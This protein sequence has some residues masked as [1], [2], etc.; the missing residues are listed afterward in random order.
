MGLLLFYLG[1]SPLTGSGGSI[2]NTVGGEGGEEE[3]DIAN[4][5]G[6]INTNTNSSSSSSSRSMNTTALTNSEASA[7]T[8]RVAVA[9]EAN[10][11]GTGDLVKPSL[12]NSNSVGTGGSGGG[13]CIESMSTRERESIDLGVDIDVDKPHMLPSLRML[14]G[15]N[16]EFKQLLYNSIILSVGEGLGTEF[17]SFVFIIFPSVKHYKR[18]VQLATFFFFAQFVLGAAC[19]AIT[20]KLFLEYMKVDKLV[21]LRKIIQ[22]F[23]C[24]CGV[25]VLISIPSIVQ[26]AGGGEDVLDADSDAAWSVVYVYL[27]LQVMLASLFQT[28]SAI[29]TLL[30]RDVIRLDELRTGTDRYNTFQ[31]ALTVPSLIIVTFFIAVPQ[32]VFYSSGYNVLPYTFGPTTSTNGTD[33]TIYVDDDLISSKVGLSRD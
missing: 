23:I 8:T 26:E 13:S 4:A 1:N 7:F 14:Y 29:N 22:I 3:K 16:P 18:L 20:K 15:Q 32:A 5:S 6:R 33:A 21:V 9:V 25:E 27:G 31:A 10:S 19:T 28:A 17:V 24:V 2:E 12:A 30:I 11:G